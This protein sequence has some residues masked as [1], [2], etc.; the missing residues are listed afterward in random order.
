MSSAEKHHT[1]YF[2]L[3]ARFCSAYC[4]FSRAVGVFL[5]V[6]IEIIWWTLQRD[7]RHK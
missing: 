3:T 5:I 7:L 1:K 6:C 2:S 4:G